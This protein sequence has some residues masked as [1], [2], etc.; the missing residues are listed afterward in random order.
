MN[1][2]YLYAL[3][4]AL[5]WSFSGICTRFVSAPSLIYSGLASLM[6]LT[7]SAMVNKQKLKVTKFTCMVAICQFLMVITFV[8]ANRL[9]TIGNTIVLQYSSIIFVLI[10][11]AIDRH[12]LPK[13]YQ[14]F[15]MVMAVIGMGIFFMGDFDFSSFLGNALAIISGVFFGLQFYLN[16]KEQASPSSSLTIQYILA[17]V[18]ML[19][20]MGVE[21]EMVISVQDVCVSLLIGMVIT[22]L[23]G[24]YFAKCIQLIPAFSANVICMS[25]IFLAP[26]W[27]FILLGE[28]GST[29]SLIGAAFMIFALFFNVYKEKK[30]LKEG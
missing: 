24:M 23:S 10:F 27:A 18:C 12:H 15:V 3:I 19:V 28:K 9:T 1:S 11:E 13:T 2:G 22:Y 20:Y 26:C 5:L 25:E 4:T 29:T 17:I 14:L 7:L 21:H 30:L 8:F 6:A 16:T